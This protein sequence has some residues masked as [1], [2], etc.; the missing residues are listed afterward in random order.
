MKKQQEVR[1]LK[2]PKPLPGVS[3]RKTPS[4]TDSVQG[5]R[6]VMSKQVAQMVAEGELEAWRKRGKA[7]REGTQAPFGSNSEGTDQ[8]TLKK[9][10]H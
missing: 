10:V 9:K 2:V 7:A 8:N 1:I 5:A 3:G 6:N 4:I